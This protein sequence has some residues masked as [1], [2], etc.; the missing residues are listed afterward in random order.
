MVERLVGTLT[1]SRYR[2][3]GHHAGSVHELLDVMSFTGPV[4][5]DHEAAPTGLERDLR[6][7]GGPHRG[8][9]IDAALVVGVRGDQRVARRHSVELLALGLVEAPHILQP[10]RTRP[11]AQEQ[12][13]GAGTLSR[14]DDLGLRLPVRRPAEEP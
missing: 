2:S 14:H 5:V 6:A 11:G 12:R 7:V 10:D 9:V 4:S 13:I 1:R 3:T 8:A